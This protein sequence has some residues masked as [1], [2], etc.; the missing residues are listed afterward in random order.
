MHLNFK[1][2]LAGA[3]IGFCAWGHS[4]ILAVISLFMISLYFQAKTRAN[5]FY[6]AV[7][8]YLAASRGLFSG[9]V[10][11]Y[12]QITYAFTIWVGSA[13]IISIG[14][15]I[16]WSENSKKKVFAFL[17]AIIFITIPPIGFVGWT[18][19]LLT[20][21]LIFPGFGFYGFGLLLLMFILIE[22]YGKKRWIISSMIVLL[23][24]FFNRNFIPIKDNIFYGAE[25]NFG[26]LYD[27][28]TNYIT[29]Y[30]RQMD[31]LHVTK[32]TENKFVVLPENAV[33]RWTNL[34]MMAWA[35]LPL[36]KRIFAGASIYHENNISLYD[37]VLLEITPTNYKILYR[38]RVPVLI[39]MW[40]PWGNTGAK[41][42]LFQENPVVNIDKIGN[43]GVL[44]CY[45][46]LLFYT[47]L[48]TMAYNPER[49]IAIS[50]LWWAKGT[51]IK[52]IEISS[53]QLISSL[54]KKP[55]TIS[56]NE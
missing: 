39:S 23:A 36:G 3:M 40:Q 52:A 55:L 6:A 1:Y 34:N 31:Y 47:L 8:Y 38:Q 56:M 49:I 17:F 48:E 11:Y 15:T 41:A 20:A 27:E 2:A 45:E 13:L 25:T 29:D 44:I 19:P 30:K 10:V 53:L 37:N 28:N 35:N 32:S 46:Q 43:V 7:G 51:S 14:W 12:D 21:G 24:L 22:V 50:N 42:Y 26:K 16:L 54:F 4:T 33:G 5:F 9:I 18:N